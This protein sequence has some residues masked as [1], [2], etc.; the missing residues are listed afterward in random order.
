MH[1]CALSEARACRCA[2]AASF[3]QPAHPG[4]L[5]ARRTALRRPR[6]PLLRLP[7][8]GCLVCIWARTPACVRARSTSPPP[9]AHSLRQ[10]PQNSALPA[11]DLGPPPLPGSACV[12]GAPTSLVRGPRVTSCPPS[13]LR[14]AHR[15][16]APRRVARS[17]RTQKTSFSTKLYTI[18]PF[19]TKFPV[20]CRGRDCKPSSARG[21]RARR[22][23]AARA[24]ARGLSHGARQARAAG[25]PSRSLPLTRGRLPARAKN[26]PPLHGVQGT[27]WL[28]ARRGTHGVGAGRVRTRQRVAV[29]GRSWYASLDVGAVEEA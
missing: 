9:Q 25:T 5:H 17:F 8:R 18:S 27:P 29:Y 24:R 10:V 26:I 20:P 2:A 4:H 3:R 22:P 21:R 16:P 19:G 14:S 15:T 28:S 13:P 6:L 11:N 12:R 7:F 1:P 23:P